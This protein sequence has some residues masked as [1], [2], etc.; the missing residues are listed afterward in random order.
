MTVHPMPDSA[1]RQLD[2]LTAQLSVLRAELL[3]EAGMLNRA[4]DAST[5]LRAACR[6][7]DTELRLRALAA[8]LPQ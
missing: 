6:I 3:V 8:R 4:A 2:R 5:D 1:E 7:R